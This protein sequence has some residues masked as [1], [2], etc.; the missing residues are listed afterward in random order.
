MSSNHL[1]STRLYKWTRTGVWNKLGNKGKRSS[2]FA[3]R[4]QARARPVVL[5][6][7]PANPSTQARLKGDG[8][9]LPPAP[10]NPGAPLTEVQ[11]LLHGQRGRA[12]A[13][14]EID[15]AGDEAGAA[16]GAGAAQHKAGRLHLEPPRTRQELVEEG[17]TCEGCRERAPGLV[18]RFVG[19]CTQGG[20]DRCSGGIGA[21]R[22]GI[23]F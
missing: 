17:W 15:L 14:E 16:Q 11:Q 22:P 12:V 18:K 4:S 8:K 23:K 21:P 10:R 7:R 9:G 13:G 1:V 19:A 20:Q 2:A 5:A 3:S 6:P